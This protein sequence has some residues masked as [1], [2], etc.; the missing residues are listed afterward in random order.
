M[1][2]FSNYNLHRA[3]TTLKTR[4]LSVS[5]Y[6]SC[7][8]CNLATLKDLFDYQFWSQSVLTLNSLP[9]FKS[10]EASHL[11]YYKPKQDSWFLASLKESENSDNTKPQDFSQQESDFQEQ[12]PPPWIYSGLPSSLILKYCFLKTKVECHLPIIFTYLSGCSRHLD[13]RKLLSV[14]I[15]E[16]RTQDIL[17]KCMLNG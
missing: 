11:K 10:Q 17:T 4:I 7:R 9:I 15:R 2:F 12:Q 5:L 14:T 8:G 3:V 6:L 13:L 1:N 16:S